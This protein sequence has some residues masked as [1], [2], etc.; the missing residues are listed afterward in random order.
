VADTDAQDLPGD[1]A[2]LEAILAAAWSLLERGATLATEDWHWPVL[3]CTDPREPERPRADARVVVLRDVDRVARQLALHS[4]R[5]AHKLAQLRAAPDACLVF[6]DR[7]RALQLRVWGDVSV[8]AGDERA[9]RA[10]QGLGLRSR[11]AYLAPRTPGTVADAPD[12]NLPDDRPGTSQDDDRPGTPQD[13]DRDDAGGRRHAPHGAHGSH[14]T[15]DVPAGFAQFAAIVL[16]VRCMEWL[17]LGRAGHQR[18]RFEWPS[19]EATARAAWI[20]P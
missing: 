9:R 18:A 19:Q 2:T 17:R 7:H 4:D 10:W 12:P 20:R 14:A 5:R 13:D 1:D 3:A 15:H 16:H 11:R 6:H 8:H